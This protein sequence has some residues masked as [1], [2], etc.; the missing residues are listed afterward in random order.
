MTDDRPARG[1]SAPDRAPTDLPRRLRLG[2]G[3]G[4][5][6]DRGRR[7][8]GR[9]HAV[10]LGHLQRTCRAGSATATPVDV[11]LRPLPPLRRGRRADAR[12]GDRRLPVLAVLAAAPAHTAATVPNAAGIAF[13][14]RLVDELLEAGITPWVTPLPLGPAP[15]P[16]RRG[17]LARPRHRRPLRRVRRDRRGRARRPCHALDHPQ[18]AVV[19]GV[20]RLRLRH[21]RPRP[22][23]PDRRGRVA[24]TTSCSGTAWPSRRSGPQAPDAQVGI[25]LNL[26]PVTPA[27]DAARRRRRS[28]AGSTACTTAGSSTRCF[29]GSYPRTCSAD[30]RAAPGPTSCR[31]GDLEVDRHAARLPRASTTTPAT[32]CGH[33]PTRASNHAEFVGPALTRAANGWEVDPDGLTEVLTR[34]TRDYTALPLFVTENGSAWEDDRGARRPGRRPGAHSH[35]S[36]PTCRPAWLPVEQGADRRGLLRVV[37]ARQL[38]VGR[39]LR[40]AVRSRARRLRHA[41]AGR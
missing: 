24:P 12:A 1:S 26:Y 15:G 31:D 36:P 27:D 9:S 8:R 18:R 2:C 32:T 13:Y 39:G 7:R 34:V 23:R 38:R 33:R 14:D 41:G 21:P 28:R 35:S 30:L 19:L 40:H 4:G 17:R 3:H 37:A 6:P 16:R 20:P 29:T 5:V 25:T 11:R 22:R 10:D